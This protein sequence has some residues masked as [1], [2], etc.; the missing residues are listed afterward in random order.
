[1]VRA[2]IVLL[3]LMLMSSAALAEKRIALLIGNE[4]YSSKIGR[5]ANHHN[6]VALLVKSLKGLGLGCDRA[7]FETGELWDRSL[8]LTKVTRKLK[9][10]AGNATHFVV[11]DAC[12][13]CFTRFGA[14]KGLR[15]G[16]AR[17]WH[18]RVC[19]HRGWSS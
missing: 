9:R 10:D 2:A 12:R 17:E 14:V 8:Q 1:M 18:D 13:N 3:L 5:L 16:L 15:S 7:R 4:A 6:L 19:G 11:F